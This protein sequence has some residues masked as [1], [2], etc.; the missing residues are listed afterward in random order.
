MQFTNKKNN[1]HIFT[2]YPDDTPNCTPRFVLKHKFMQ[3]HA[4]WIRPLLL[5]LHN[6]PHLQVLL[7]LSICL[8]MMTWSD[9]V[10]RRIGRRVWDLRL[11][12]WSGIRWIS[13]ERASTLL[14]TQTSLPGSLIPFPYSLLIQPLS[15]VSPTEQD[16]C[17]R[18]GTVGLKEA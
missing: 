5:T 14:T 15:S 4:W 13:D 9:Q 18:R 12:E 7:T 8:Q 10:S 2:Y 11:I 6:L 16:A 17:W 3:T 1:L